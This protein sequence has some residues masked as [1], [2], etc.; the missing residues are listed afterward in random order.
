MAKPLE[1]RKQL[2]NHMVDDIARATPSAVWAET[3][4]STAS[5]E[6][7]FR[8]ITYAMLANAINGVAWWMRQTLGPAHDFETLAYFGPWDIRYILLLL[9][10]VKAGYK[11]SHLDKTVSVQPFLLVSEALLRSAVVQMVF[12]SP[13]YS[14]AELA[15]LLDEL[16]CKRILAPSTSPTIV[17]ELLALHPLNNLIKVQEVEEILAHEYIHFAYP[18]SFVS[19]RQEPLVVLHT[20]DTPSHPKPILCTHD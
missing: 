11:V 16:K 12:P 18:K 14:V 19:A 10:S 15:V 13:E 20:S 9:G 17:P 6:P 1:P 7:G 2:L 8:K 3:P 4:I 5:Y